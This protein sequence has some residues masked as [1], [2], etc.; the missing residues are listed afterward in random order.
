MKTYRIYSTLA[1][2][3]K[4][5]WTDEHGTTQEATYDAK[6]VTKAVDHLRARGYVPF[7]TTMIGGAKV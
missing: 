6:G 3:Y 5:V 4:V 7:W 1:S 2:D